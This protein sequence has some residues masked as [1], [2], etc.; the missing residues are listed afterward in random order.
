MRLDWTT[1][2]ARTAAG[3]IL[4]LLGVAAPQTLQAQSPPSRPPLPD[5][6]SRAITEAHDP[7]QDQVDEAIAA[8]SRRYLRTDMHTPWQIMHGL[9]AFRQDFRIKH[10]GEKISALDWIATGPTYQGLPWFETTRYGARAQPYTTDYAFQGHTNQFLAILA[11]CNLPEDF[12]LETPDG[13]VT[14]GDLV[15]HAQM[16]VT[17]NRDTAWTLWALSHYL[18]PDARWQNAYGRSWSVERLVGL[19]TRQPVNAGVCGGTHGLFALSYARNAR[20]QS[21]EELQGPWRAAHAKIHR[22]VEWARRLQNSDGSF[23]SEF[24]AG[25]SSTRDLEDRIYTSGHTLE[26][27]MMALP[28]NRLDEPWVRK[29]VAAVARDLIASRDRA[30][31]CSPLYHAVHGL[32]LYRDRTGNEDHDEQPAVHKVLKPPVPELAPED[33]A[34]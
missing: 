19:Q 15:R 30:L 23:S 14:V 17:D 16:T 5:E 18:Q 26:F 1:W 24:F 6:S 20:L 11:M 8:S 28:Q 3:L 9:L 33:P 32:I 4:I 31:E 7:L 10:D 25:R 21:G 27:L 2:D 22:Y 12:E 29:G 34:P 13:A